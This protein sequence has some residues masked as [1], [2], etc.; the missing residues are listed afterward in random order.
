[1]KKLVVLAQKGDR[2]AMSRLFAVYYPN[3]F[4]LAR[5]L[6]GNDDLACD[7]TQETFVDV[8]KNISNLKAPEAFPAWLNKITYHQCTRYFKKK[9]EL[10]SQPD[11]EGQTVFDSLPEERS[12]RIPDMAAEDCELKEI[13]KNLLDSLPEAQRAALI[14][15]Y[16]DEMSVKEISYLQNATEST[17]K[18][19]LFHGRKALRA[20]VEKYEREHSVKLGAV[21]IA[22]LLRWCC[23]DSFGRAIPSGVAEK[24]AAAVPNTVGASVTAGQSVALS[25]SMSPLALKITA[26]SLAAAITVGGGAYALS[27]IK[28]DSSRSQIESSHIENISE[29]SSSFS[30][31]TSETVSEA[32]QGVDKNPDDGFDFDQYMSSFVPDENNTISLPAYDGIRILEG[33]FDETRDTL[34]SSD[35]SMIKVGHDGWLFSREAGTAYVAYVSGFNNHIRIFRVEITEEI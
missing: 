25:S 34:Y 5:K 19:R 9:K 2:E 18:A 4:S 15:Y 21:Y 10:L 32:P 13:I 14:M 1:M 33:L 7:I 30:G 35:E 26:A 22:P 16:F 24:A 12:D 8:V 29:D 17:V 3:V 6:V 28:D 20:R 27:R 11:E 31:E 23:E